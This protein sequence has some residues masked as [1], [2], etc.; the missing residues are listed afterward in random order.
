MRL[1]THAV[2]ALTLIAI[3]ACGGSPSS[4]TAPIVPFAGPLPPSGPTP[5]VR[6]GEIT[7]VAANPAPGGRV[8]LGSCPEGFNRPNHAPTAQLFCSDDL[9]MTFDVVVDRD[10]PNAMLS[11]TFSD[12]YQDCAFATSP[13]LA[14]TAGG[15]V[16]AAASSVW[17]YGLDE[18]PSK[19]AELGCPTLP[20]VT[21]GLRVRLLDLDVPHP[22][23][24]V[25]VNNLPISY[26]FA[27]PQ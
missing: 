24:A 9:R 18:D 23:T 10:I 26:T 16:S 12:G 20:R 14:L 8:T 5:A 21:N 3:S 22:N 15:R 25:F 1:F 13:R 17:F 11:L 7:L 2:A 27:V 4:P 6:N 19:P